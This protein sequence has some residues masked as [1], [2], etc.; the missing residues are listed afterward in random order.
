MATFQDIHEAAA[1]RNGG[2]AALKDK[3]PQAKS[4]AALRAV[5]DDR[6]LSAMSLRIFSAGLKH[7]MVQAKWPAFEEVFHGFAPR[8]VHAM[9][10]EALEALMG[11]ARIIRH[12]GKIKSVRANAAAIR[13]IEDEAGGMGDWLAARPRFRRWQRWFMGSVMAA[14]AIRILIP[15]K[16]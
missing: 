14:L 11:E 1:A 10:D 6:Y 9:A 5:S 12:W 7:S 4:D 8:R 16:R 2:L 3:L 15:E 13:T